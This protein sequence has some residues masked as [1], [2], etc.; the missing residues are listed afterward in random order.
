MNVSPGN[1]GR[2]V[3]NGIKLPSYPSYV[4]LS[5]DCETIL[6]AVPTIGYR[7]DNWTGEIYDANPKAIC[8]TGRLINIA[9]GADKLITANFS[10]IL[11]NWLIA[12]IVVA[13]AAPLLLRWRRR[14]S[15]HLLQT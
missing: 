9:A 5:L 7:F 12:I 3:Y 15:K 10:P 4:P 1:G 8:E 2:V 11:P 14:R 6:E 13:I